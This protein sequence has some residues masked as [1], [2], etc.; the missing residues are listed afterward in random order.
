M[1]DTIKEDILEKYLK[2]ELIND[3]SLM[4]YTRSLCD[5]NFIDV[6]VRYI[7]N[8]CIKERFIVSFNEKNNDTF[9]KV[10]DDKEAIVVYKMVDGVVDANRLYLVNEHTYCSDDFIDVLVQKKF[11]K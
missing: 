2:A 8:N 7:E 9:I 4:I 6:R 10:S 3:N 1:R 5:E 11:R